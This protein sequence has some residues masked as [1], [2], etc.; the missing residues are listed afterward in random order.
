MWLLT[1]RSAW[2]QM[3]MTVVAQATGYSPRKVSCPR[4]TPSAP[5]STRLATSV[6]SARVGRGTSTIESHSRVTNTG[7][8]RRLA[9]P[10]SRCCARM[11]FSGASCTPRLPR[12]NT[13]PS[14]A[15]RMSSWLVSPAMLSILA[16]TWVSVR[17]ICARMWRQKLTS[18]ALRQKLRPTNSMLFA[19][20]KS[21]SSA[22]SSSVSASRSEPQSNCTVS[23]CP[24]SATL[25]S[26]THVTHSPSIDSTRSRAV[27][28]ASPEERYMPTWMTLP[29]CA[30]RTSMRLTGSTLLLGTALSSGVTTTR[31]PATNSSTPFCGLRTRLSGPV[32]STI[33]AH[34]SP[35]LRIAARRLSSVSWWNSREPH[36]KSSRAM[37]IPARSSCSSTSTERLAGP[38]VQH[39]RVAAQ[40]GA[41]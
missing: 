20:W 28:E 14:A 31:S 25:F 37:C 11:V 3:R 40:P 32:V 27:R 12:L 26:T 2:S 41:L 13:R 24:S 1:W 17:P 16:N 35:V 7:L 4:I 22:M 33:T 29:T 39:S 38:S 36:E 6:A 10:S 23:C 8:P 5:L 9:A 21:L 34:S 19:A 15:S 18:A 30:E